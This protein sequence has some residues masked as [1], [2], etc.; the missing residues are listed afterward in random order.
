MN[1]DFQLNSN[2]LGIG[3][4]CISDFPFTKMELFISNN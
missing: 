3:Y 4:Y 1:T 2:T